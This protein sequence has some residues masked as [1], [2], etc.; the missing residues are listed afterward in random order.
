MGYLVIILIKYIV[1]C[2]SIWVCMFW[3]R[4][5]GCWRYG[6]EICKVGNLGKSFGVC[7]GLLNIGQ[8]TGRHGG[9]MN[10]IQKRF[11][12]SIH[13]TECV[14]LVWVAGAIPVSGSLPAHH[15]SQLKQAGSTDDNA[16]SATCPQ[17]CQTSSR[18]P[19]KVLKT[20]L[21]KFGGLE[22]NASQRRRT[23]TEPPNDA[24]IITIYRVFTQR[25]RSYI[26]IFDP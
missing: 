12:C 2:I 6:F 14:V 17:G 4:L 8:R 5:V 13:C 16:A 21:R 11:A 24:H 20:G 25:H 26:L 23:N 15:L 18:R 3:Y 7:I 10:W 19:T 9:L 22:L 1:N